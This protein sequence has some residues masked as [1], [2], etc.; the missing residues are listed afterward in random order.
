MNIDFSAGPKPP[1]QPCQGAGGHGNA[2]GGGRQSGPGDMDEDR[3]AASRNSRADV[4]VN[5]D[6][7]VIKRIV[8]S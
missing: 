3:T 6:H 1:Y 7:Q 2:A 8:S 5:L 4:V